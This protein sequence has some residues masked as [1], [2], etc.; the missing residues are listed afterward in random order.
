M[1]RSWITLGSALAENVWDTR[2]AVRAVANPTLQPKKWRRRTFLRGVVPG[3]TFRYYVRS[4]V[5][6]WLRNETNDLPRSG[7]R[8][9]SPSL[10]NYF[11]ERNEL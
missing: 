7:K 4:P 11:V 6:F 1:T 3:P 9:S 10:V 5:R 8:K 2:H